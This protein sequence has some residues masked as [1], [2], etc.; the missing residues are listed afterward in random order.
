MPWAARPA[1]RVLAL[2]AAA[3]FVAGLAWRALGTGGD[4]P[5]DP[6]TTGSGGAGVPTLASA[7]RRTLAPGLE[8]F[9]AA[10]GEV[11]SNPTDGPLAVALAAD[12]RIDLEPGAVLALERTGELRPA[13]RLLDG[14]AR[15][16]AA[17]HA[18]TSIGLGNSPAAVRVA[19]GGAFRAELARAS[20]P[21]PLDLER[22]GER[23]LFGRGQWFAPTWLT[24][25]SLAGELTWATVAGERI[26]IASTLAGPVVDERGTLAPLAPERLAAL[27]KLVSAVAPVPGLDKL[28]EYM[29]FEAWMADSL[30]F[31]LLALLD[32]DEVLWVPV[33]RELIRRVQAHDEARWWTSA[34]SILARSETRAGLQAARALWRAA[35]ERFDTD[36]LL[37]L[38]EVGAAPFDREL[39][40]FLERLPRVAPEGAPN[41]STSPTSPASAVAAKLGGG[42][43]ADQDLLVL[44]ALARGDVRYTARALDLT[45][46]LAALRR[47]GEVSKRGERALLAAAVLARAGIADPWNDTVREALRQIED[48]LDAGADQPAAQLA[49][50][51]DAA[52][53]RVGLAPYAASRD[54]TPRLA[55]FDRHQHAAV[56]RFGE[57][58]PSGSFVS[59][60]DWLETWRTR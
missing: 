32:E 34:V 9:P 21:S 11:I 27:S 19:A 10:F 1:A 54:E 45:A 2:A 57:L 30:E 26:V 29:P 16:Q 6:S 24:L 15:F 39:A 41:S 13:P 18:A 56:A 14:A 40:A 38:A 60:T 12:E 7:T 58:A 47:D 28:P 33:G 59:L 20:G 46:P 5:A 43:G 53:E 55:Y 3:L 17:S 50:L 36:A 23:A 25:E 44:A 37:H 4:A 51:L 48:R 52:A 42:P 49:G 22:D 31:E 35:P 8:A